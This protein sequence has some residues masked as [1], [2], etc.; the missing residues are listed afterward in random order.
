MYQKNKNIYGGLSIFQ[1]TS[2]YDK[3]QNSRLKSQCYIMVG[4]SLEMYRIRIFKTQPHY[5][6]FFSP[7]GKSVSRSSYQGNPSVFTS[8]LPGQSSPSHVQGTQSGMKNTGPLSLGPSFVKLC[9]HKH[10][11][12]GLLVS[13]NCSSLAQ[14]RII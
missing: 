10:M 9:G 7:W 8:F 2:S 5:L 14:P 1:I 6:F 4:F 13:F 11:T 12:Q 3:T